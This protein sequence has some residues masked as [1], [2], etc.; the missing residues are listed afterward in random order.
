MGLPKDW[1]DDFLE[2]PVVLGLALLSVMRRR[3]SSRLADWLPKV[4]LAN[5]RDDTDCPRA[6]VCGTGIG[7]DVDIARG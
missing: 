5:G 1:Y 2:T 4:L 7:M 3:L 6:G